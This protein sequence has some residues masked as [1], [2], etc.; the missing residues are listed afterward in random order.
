MTWYQ[1]D[2][3]T[4]AEVQR[5]P[6]PVRRRPTPSHDEIMHKVRCDTYHVRAIAEVLGEK[7]KHVPHGEWTAAEFAAIAKRQAEMRRE[8]GL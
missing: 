6:R 7:R 3:W 5:A 8:L 2:G 4:D 1:D